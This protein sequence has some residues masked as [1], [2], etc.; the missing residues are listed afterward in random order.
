MAFNKHARYYKSRNVNNI[1]T[2]TYLPSAT[3]GTIGKSF[4]PISVEKND[5]GLI[6]L[7]TYLVRPPLETTSNETYGLADLVHEEANPVIA[8]PR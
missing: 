6:Y 8:N 5:G 3:R 7:V 1:I 2:Y 4:Q